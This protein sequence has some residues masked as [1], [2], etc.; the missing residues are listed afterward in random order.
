MFLSKAKGV[1]KQF[2]TDATIGERWINEDGHDFTGNT[3]A[4]ADDALLQLRNN[5]GPCLDTPKITLG[6]QPVR[7]SYRLACP[8]LQV[9]APALHADAPRPRRSTPRSRL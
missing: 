5:D 4:E 9:T 1:R 7:T 6:W 8:W 3:R 2:R